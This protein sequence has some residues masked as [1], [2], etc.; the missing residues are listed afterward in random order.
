MDCGISGN[1]NADEGRNEEKNGTDDGPTHYTWG[2]C[3]ASCPQCWGEET[4]IDIEDH[5]HTLV[6]VALEV[7]GDIISFSERIIASFIINTKNRDHMLI[8]PMKY[9]RQNYWQE[10]AFY[11]KLFR[12]A[13]QEVYNAF[14]FVTFRDVGMKCETTVLQVKYIGDDGKMNMLK[15]KHAQKQDWLDQLNPPQHACVAHE[16]GYD[17]RF[18][19]GIITI[20]MSCHVDPQPV[21]NRQLLYNDDLFAQRLKNIVSQ[22]DRMS[23]SHFGKLAKIIY[24]F[25]EHQR[26]SFDKITSKDEPPYKTVSKPFRKLGA[27]VSPDKLLNS[28]SESSSTSKEA[29][30]PKPAK[31]D[32]KQVQEEKD[33]PKTSDKERRRK[34]A[35]EFEHEPQFSPEDRRYYDNR[36]AYQPPRRYEDRGY[37][38][39]NT[40]VHPNKMSNPWIMKPRPMPQQTGQNRS[41]N[42]GQKNQPVRQ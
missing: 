8:K 35:V 19:D 4:R 31:T 2:E 6:K 37:E 36:P 40:Y 20:T 10:Q 22:K 11:I 9:G 14:P 34:P 18:F 24:A 26:M 27:D 3:C 23:E 41:G 28:S 17:P 33:E 29:K 30:P 13:E 42:P 38:R 1:Q 32:V 21:K 7:P 25:D 12:T 15:A 16:E 5:H 39:E